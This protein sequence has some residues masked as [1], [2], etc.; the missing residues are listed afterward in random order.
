MIYNRFIIL[1]LIIISEF[2]ACPESEQPKNLKG[3]NSIELSGVKMREFRESMSGAELIADYLKY[4]RDNMELLVSKGVVITEIK[5]GSLNDKARV[6]FDKGKYNSINKV[7]SLTSVSGILLNTGLQIETGN[8]KYE[9]IKG[10][11]NTGEVVKISG[12][13]FEFEGKGFSGNIKDGL[14]VFNEGITARIFK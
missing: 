11:I 9:M 12:E 3:E 2:F 5:S 6:L 1:S 4:N 10:D 13:N 7:F 14:F 8:L